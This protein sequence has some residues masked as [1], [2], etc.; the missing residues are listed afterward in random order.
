MTVVVDASDDRLGA[1]ARAAAALGA[2]RVVVLPT[3]TVYGV[4]A[5]AFNPAATARIFLAKAR[6]RR[7]PLPVLVHSPAQLAGIVPEVPAAGEWLMAAYWPGPLTLVLPAQ[8][9]L[10]WDL[11]DSA[12]TV[13]VRMPLDEVALDVIRAVGP[14][15]V[16]SANRSGEPAANDVTAAR[17]ALGDN[18]DV[19]VDDGPRRNATPS[20]I[21]DLTRSEPLLIREGDL[22]SDEVMAVARGERAGPPGTAGA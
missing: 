16:T 11:G 22:P 10:A 5:D 9:N 20:T 6:S 8:D 1:V 7:F 13:A 2:G 19:Y 4:A 12:G 3:D 14:L 18:V 17:A 15:A 21:I